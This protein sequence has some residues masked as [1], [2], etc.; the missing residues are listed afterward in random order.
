MCK[1]CG[2][3]INLLKLTYNTYISI[4]TI[5]FRKNN[6]K[7]RKIKHNSEKIKKALT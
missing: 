7:F 4:I 3:H 1:C 2:F 5:K 6:K